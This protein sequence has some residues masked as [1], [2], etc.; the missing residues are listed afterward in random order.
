VKVA[1]ER[2]VVY[3]GKRPARDDWNKRQEKRRKRLKKLAIAE[4]SKKN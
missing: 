4:T 2:E 1:A 3:R